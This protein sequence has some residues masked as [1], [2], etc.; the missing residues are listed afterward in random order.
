MDGFDASL[1]SFQVL[2]QV[3]AASI[4]QLEHPGSWN[5]RRPCLEAVLGGV[6]EEIEPAEWDEKRPSCARDSGWIPS[7]RECPWRFNAV[8]L[9]TTS[10]EELQSESGLS[11]RLRVQ[12]DISLGIVKVQLPT[13]IVG[14]ATADLLRHVLPVCSPVQVQDWFRWASAVQMVSLKGSDGTE[15]GQ[16]AVSFAVDADPRELMSSASSDARPRAQRKSIAPRS[17]WLDWHC[18]TSASGRRIC[19]EECDE[20]HKDRKDASMSLPATLI[21]RLDPPSLPPPEQAPEGWISRRGPGGRVFW[22][23]KALGPA[24]WEQQVPSSL[25][26]NRAFFRSIMGK[27]ADLSD[28]NPLSSEIF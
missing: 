25:T 23:H 21:Q 14:E 10:V 6:Q 8:M 19:S 22:H 4:Q 9:F 24:P 5:S 17:W 28:E 1:G 27:V 11:F 16:V 3:F 18:C 2:L 7:G 15:V 26:R 13:D 20:E 12:N